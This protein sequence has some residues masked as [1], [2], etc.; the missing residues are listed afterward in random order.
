M[1]KKAISDTY[2][3]HK[4]SSA[5]IRLI[6]DSLAKRL[7]QVAKKVFWTIHQHGLSIPLM[8][9][10]FESLIAGTTNFVHGIPYVA[11]SIGFT[12]SRRPTIGVVLNPF[13]AQLYSGI[14]TKGSSLTTL[15]HD[16]SQALSSTPLPLYPAQPLDLRSSV[17]AIEF[18]SDRSGPNFTTK[19]S[20]FRNLSSAEGGMVHGLRAYGS[21]ALNLC[22]V[23]SG[24]IDAY[25]EGGCWEWDVCAGWVILE[26]AGGSIVDGNPREAPENEKSAM[27]SPDLCGRMYLAVR[28][29]RDKE[30]TE[31]WV[32]EFWSLAGG[33]MEYGR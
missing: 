9:P 1:V 33:R 30:E 24:F 13:T 3:D 11:I 5:E 19:I 26:A 17:I 7:M 27:E 6:V 28:Q 22:S 23:A 4:Y 15:S 21:A 18:G 16:L 32:R 10:S 2:P 12:V 29:G 14:R 8:V 31:K 25:W 20:T